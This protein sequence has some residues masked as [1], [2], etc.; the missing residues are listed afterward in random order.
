MSEV[1]DAVT[2]GTPKAEALITLIAWVF[3][4][5]VSQMSVIWGRIQ[6]EG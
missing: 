5:K 6:R 4:R 1:G 3:A 2:V